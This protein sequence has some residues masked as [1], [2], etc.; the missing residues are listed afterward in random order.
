MN[1]LFD[2]INDLV[3]VMA[4]R[5]SHFEMKVISLDGTMTKKKQLKKKIN[6]N[7][8]NQQDQSLENEFLK[9]DIKAS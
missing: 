6:P 1:I 7:D 9:I 2:T 8:I 3:Y 5:G 4:A